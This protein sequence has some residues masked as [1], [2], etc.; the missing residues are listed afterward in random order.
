MHLGHAPGERLLPR[1]LG[2][3]AGQRFASKGGFLV[4]L[5]RPA[6]RAPG[7]RRRLDRGR[8]AGRNLRASGPAG[9]ARSDPSHVDHRD[10]VVRGRP[11]RPRTGDAERIYR[12]GMFAV[13]G[14]TIA[15]GCARRAWA[16]EGPSGLAWR[17]LPTGAAAIGVNEGPNRHSTDRRQVP[18]ASR[19]SARDARGCDAVGPPAAIGAARERYD[20]AT[21]GA[22]RSA[23]A[24]ISDGKPPEL[25]D[26]RAFA[27]SDAD[28]AALVDYLKSLSSEAGTWSKP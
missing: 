17:E 26:C 4:A 23:R 21:L 12:D 25:P 15:R 13:V 7:G 27:L 19:V 2:L 9:D 3:A 16:I 20:D 6:G 22:A 14:R 11:D 28:S 18:A 8:E 24:S 5:R 1:D 10:G